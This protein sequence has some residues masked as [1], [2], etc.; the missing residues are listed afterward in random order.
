LR[1]CCCCNTQTVNARNVAETSW[2]QSH[3]T[4][5]DSG[6]LRLR[7]FTFVVTVVNK[8]GDITAHVSGHMSFFLHTTIRR[9]CGGIEGYEGFSS[10]LHCHKFDKLWKWKNTEA[11]RRGVPE[12][13]V[14]TQEFIDIERGIRITQH[15][16]Y[17][18]FNIF[19][20]IYIEYT[21]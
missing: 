4:T 2:T 3:S 9:Q 11:V 6:L 14:K 17:Y 10:R 7:L 18:I 12:N 8:S 19:S 16:A 13:T 5:P 21:K 1:R 20:W 15:H